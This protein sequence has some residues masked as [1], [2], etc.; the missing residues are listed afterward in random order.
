MKKCENCQEQHLGCY[1]SGRFCSSKCARGFSTKLKRQEINL[2][3]SQKV[4]GI[5]SHTGQKARI[6]IKLCPICEKEFST[7]WNKRHQTYC[8]VD[9]QQNYNR[10]EEYKKQMSEM[11][12]NRIIEG[13]H[14]N[15]GKSIKC[16][17]TF[18]DTDIKCDS[19]LEYSSLLF[20]SQTFNVKQIERC[21][22]YIEYTDYKGNQRNFIPDFII[23]TDNE[24]YVVECKH[25][26]VGNNLSQKWY[27]Y[28]E[29]S[30]IKKQ[31]LEQFCEQMDFIP[32]W[33]TNK[34]SKLY[35]NIKIK[36]KIIMK[37]M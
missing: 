14:T 31:K 20:F 7:I 15:F 28:I 9:C 21:S 8:S 37:T 6:A 12:I 1:G 29:N 11:M 16:T 25:E 2:K 19:K 32:F 35:N 5:D 23:H 3:V 33:Y 26:K 24:T 17:F 30:K 10:T 13:K 4:S 18:N 34:T 22:F 27:D 36:N